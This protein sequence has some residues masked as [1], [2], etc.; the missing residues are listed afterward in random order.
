MFTATE[1]GTPTPTDTQ[2]STPT[3]TSTVVCS[4]NPVSPTNYTEMEPVGV[5]G[6]ANGTN[7]SCATAENLGVISSGSDM[8]VHGSSALT[9][10]GS[11]GPADQDYYTFTVGTTG[12]YT[13]TLDC[14]S[15]GA[16]NNLMDIVIFGP[17][18]CNY[19]FDTGA[20]QPV[21]STSNTLNAGD[22]WIILPFP[23]NGTAPMSYRLTISPP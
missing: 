13:I 18:G 15:T 16:D 3:E 11:F 19:I 10:G 17:N 5:G 4:V 9:G 22:V 1:T 20:G 2:T 21:L 8:V 14:F 6:P 7:E 23:Y 12:L